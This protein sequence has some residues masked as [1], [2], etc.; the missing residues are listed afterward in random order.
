MRLVT[1]RQE[2]EKALQSAGF[3]PGSYLWLPKPNR[4]AVSVAGKIK[5]LPL[6]GGMSRAKLER[7]I[8]RIEGW[9]DMMAA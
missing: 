4:L 5:T 1:I 9:Q 3:A 7:V 6:R 2:T 8:G